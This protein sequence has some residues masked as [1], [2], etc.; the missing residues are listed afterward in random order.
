MRAR[1]VEQEERS[2]FIP[3]IHTLIQIWR[4][5]GGTKDKM[6]WNRMH[7]SS[8]EYQEYKF[9]FR[10]GYSK[11]FKRDVDEYLKYFKLNNFGEFIPFEWEWFE[12]FLILNTL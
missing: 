12:N 11:E 4:L 7:N 5:N 2:D 10:D 6:N 8:S 1:L 3:V 9:H